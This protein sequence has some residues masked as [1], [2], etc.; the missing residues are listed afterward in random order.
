MLFKVYDVLII[1]M[2]MM[3]IVQIL[4]PVLQAFYSVAYETRDDVQIILYAVLM[5]FR[6]LLFGV[7]VT[8]TGPGSLKLLSVILK[9]EDATIVFLCH[10]Q[11]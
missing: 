7:L 9:S 3:M 6:K 1:I 10:I 11:F 8:R 4:C 5:I 2:M